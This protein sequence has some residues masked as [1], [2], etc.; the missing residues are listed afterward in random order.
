MN[1]E[2]ENVTIYDI[3]KFIKIK[4]NKW[5]NY[6]NQEEFYFLKPTKTYNL[7]KIRVKGGNKE[8]IKFLKWIYKYKEDLYLERKYAKVQDKIN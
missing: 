1:K 5:A 6:E 8:T 7:Y 2:L 4:K 3:C